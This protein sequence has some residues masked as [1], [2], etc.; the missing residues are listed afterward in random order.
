M[1]Q[2]VPDSF[3][4]FMPAMEY[5]VE[6]GF[7]D[8][9]ETKNNPHFM[10]A[11]VAATEAYPHYIAERKAEARAEAEKSHGEKVAGELLNIGESLSNLRVSVVDEVGKESFRFPGEGFNP[12]YE[13]LEAGDD[14]LAA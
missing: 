12:R 4:E 10:R 6:R 11:M 5:D 14:R 9:P 2:E 1:E 3:G 7:Q 13:D 8:A